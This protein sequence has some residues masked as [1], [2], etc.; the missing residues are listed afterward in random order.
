MAADAGRSS[1]SK[2]SGLLAIKYTIVISVSF[3][4][5]NTVKTNDIIVADDIYRFLRMEVNDDWCVKLHFSRGFHNFESLMQL[6]DGKTYHSL[7]AQE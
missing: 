3:Y 5:A 7:D 4:I 6:P 2:Q 1:I